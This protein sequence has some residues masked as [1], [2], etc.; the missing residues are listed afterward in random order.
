MDWPSALALD[1]NGVLYFA[2]LHSNRVGK[3][4][5]GTLSTVAGTGFP[6]FDGDGVPAK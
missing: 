2:E 5:N 4:V 1:A 3:I 6:G